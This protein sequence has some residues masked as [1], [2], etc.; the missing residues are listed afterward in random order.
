M[1]WT[2]NPASRAAGVVRV[3]SDKSITH[4]AVML[5]ALAEG[6]SVI[7]DYL[8]SE[9][10]LRT[11]QAFVGMGVRVERDAR[12]LRIRGAGWKGLSAP[13]GPMDAGNSGTTVRLM[14]GILAGRPFSTRIVG[15]ESLSRRPMKRVITPLRLMGA[16]IA[17]REDTYLPLNITGKHPL[18]PIAYV[19]PVASAQVKSCILLAGL[20]IDGVTSVEE[21]IRSRDH[22][23]RM[24]VACGADISVSGTKVSVR[25]PARLNP[26][27]MTV[28]ADISS[29][30][31]FMVLGL[32]MT[33]GRIELPDVGINPTR[34]GILDVLTRMGARLN[35]T[36][37][38]I[39][40]GEP[41][42]TIVAEHS[43]LEA[44]DI[45]GDLMPRL[46]DEVPILVLA[47][48]Q[49]RGTTVIS[50][51]AELRV[52]E[53]DRIR[54]IAAELGAM[55]A[56]IEELP[57]GLIVHGPT[58]LHGA[59][60]TSHGDHRIAMTL[61]VAACIADGTTTIDG[62]ECVDTSFPGF[63]STLTGLL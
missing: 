22:T 62:V 51:A 23:E 46:I 21:P 16:D 8:A 45:T 7:T 5:G 50:G 35:I 38:K 24:L 11:V 39:L 56:R 61:A 52:K 37:R 2:L 55:G 36:N 4:R 47:A 6:E 43:V 49:A 34:D 32:I 27:S 58:R 1:K 15:D 26:L 17:A 63:L 57:D 9:D 18:L 29:A 13:S 54:T 42:A 44:A 30:A 12:V 60:V 48:T 10:C 20:E 31:F 59:A 53:S 25:G 40:S 41:V 28:P 14:S 19:S 33:E 3:P